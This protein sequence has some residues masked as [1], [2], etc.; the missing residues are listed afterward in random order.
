M[1]EDEHDEQKRELPRDRRPQRRAAARAR[2]RPAVLGAAAGRRARARAERR[3]PAPARASGRRVGAA[4]RRGGRRRARGHGGEVPVDLGRS[5]AAR[6]AAR[7]PR[8]ERDQVH[9][10]R[11]AGRRS[12]S[13]AQT[14]LVHFEV[15]D[16][17]IGISEEERE[18]LF[19]RF[20]R[21][22][23]G[24]RAPDPGNRPRSLHLEGDRRGTRRPHRGRQ[25]RRRG[26]D[27]RRRA[28]RSPS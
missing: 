28:A 24:A 18:R 3:R 27:V 1:L 8:L 25:H 2:L 10:A 23:N 15:S 22:Q 20:F 21:S 5:G 13:S 6:A 4:A 19:E 11:R 14:G 12:L 9:A 16:T 26:H 17:G 7:Q